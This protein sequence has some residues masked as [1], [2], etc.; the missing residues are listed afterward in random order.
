MQRFINHPVTILTL[1][2]ALSLGIV[3]GTKIGPVIYVVNEDRGWGV[4]SGD[5]LAF[6]PAIGATL[7][8]WRR[9]RRT[10]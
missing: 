10:M 8:A 9:I 4:H 6:I 7:L 1:G 5:F 2:A 3:K